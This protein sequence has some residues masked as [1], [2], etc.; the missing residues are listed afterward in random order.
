[1]K[2]TRDLAF[3]V[4]IPFVLVS[5]VASALFSWFFT[6]NQSAVYNRQQLRELNVV[7]DAVAASA[8]VLLIDKD[9]LALENLLR[10]SSGNVGLSVGI[11]VR[12]NNGVPE[13]V[14]AN[15]PLFDIEMMQD[16]LQWFTVSKPVL[17]NGETDWSVMVGI[18]QARIADQLFR[19]N[20]PVYLALVISVALSCILFYL[21][22][23]QFSEP[24]MET[25]RFTEKLLKGDFSG[26]LSGTHGIAEIGRLNDSLNNLKVTL[27]R[28]RTRNKELTSGLEF[29][30]SKRTLELKMVLQR[31]NAA[32]EMARLANFTY[33]PGND[34]WEMS[35]NINTIMGGDCDR[36]A[37]LEEFL[38]AVSPEGRSETEKNIRTAI[39]ATDRIHLDFQLDPSIRPG[40]WWFSLIAEFKRDANSGLP[41][42][43][44]TIQDITD[45]KEFE[46]QI[47]RLALV[48]RLTSNGVI[49]TDASKIITWVNE[50]ME[51]ITGYRLEEMIG[52]SPKMFQSTNTSDGVRQLIRDH[53]DRMQ[54]IRVELEN[55]TK[56][57]N[58]YWIELHIEP[59]PG[60][61]GKIVGFLA[62]Q[63]D[64]TERKRYEENLRHALA[65]E[66]ELNLMKS[67]F[68][69]MTSHEF[70]TPLTSIQ[71]SAE[72]L[73]M[74]LAGQAGITAQRSDRYL[75]RIKSEVSRMTLLMDDILLLGRVEAGR[76]MFRVV[77]TDLQALMNEVFQDRRLLFN[78]DRCVMVEHL[79]APRRVR[80]DP[81]L[82]SHI[83]N[84]LGSNALKYSMGSPPPVA[85]VV[86]LETGFSLSICDNGIGIPEAEIPNLFQSFYRAS[87][88]S[89]I[90]GTGLGLV[91]VKQFTD[92]HHG[93]IHV[94]SSENSGTCVTLEFAYSDLE[95]LS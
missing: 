32:Q 88:V 25:T 89:N 55:V 37:N 49:I 51:K 1:M 29:Q 39:A 31:L 60:P 50:G 76:V 15:D 47:D 70:R 52:H 68:I 53:L 18:P 19:L 85:T 10:I 81:V 20:F 17:T 75:S 54:P 71:S 4:W 67:R 8:R 84:N 7:A 56:A 42:L 33:W 12:N 46:A 43:A 83:L 35:P 13:V 59:I 86:W 80:I 34:V 2:L 91:I 95:T 9:E 62:I 5:L 16:S 69:S 27:A 6:R 93:R 61:Y 90:Q 41:Y 73:E 66:T 72:L 58:P 40:T 57:G 28:Q 3:R 26:H 14:S 44:G 11:M 87:N 78:D 77:E 22:S 65:R 79:G 94:K 64:I 30:V 48:A 23:L 63:V 21:M 38:H 92:L 36:I 74:L 45:R 24:V 82:F